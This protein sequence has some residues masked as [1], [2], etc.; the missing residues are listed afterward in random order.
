MLAEHGFA[1]LVEVAGRRIL[2]DTGQGAALARNAGRLGIELDRLDAL[3]LSHGH[4][5]HTGG[6]PLLVRRIPKLAI[7]AHPDLFV[8]RY[9]RGASPPHRQIGLPPATREALGTRLDTIRW[10][11]GPTRVA[12]GVWVTGAIPRTNDFEDPGGPFFLDP[13]CSR[14]DPILG[15]QALWLETPAGIVVVVGCA[16]A[17]VANTLDHIAALT[18]AVRFAG[19]IGGMHLIHAGEERLKQTLVTLDKYGVRWIGPCHCTG[20]FA[21]EWLSQKLGPRCRRV[22]A[23]TRLVIE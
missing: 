18:G 8:P 14:P 9:S 20:E 12:E 3:V 11:S 13:V 23:G 16:H 10:T 2:F 17:G 7:Y 19:V 6:I 4:Y 5:D 22:S 15:D 1:L 21:C